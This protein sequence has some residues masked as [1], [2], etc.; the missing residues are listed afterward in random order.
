M[1]SKVN[2]V[3]AIM[4]YQD[5]SLCNL[6]IKSSDAGQVCDNLRKYYLNF[7]RIEEGKDNA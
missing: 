1:D 5:M 2:H 6:A 4:K 7:F 3:R